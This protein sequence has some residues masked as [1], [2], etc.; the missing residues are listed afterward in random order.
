M[1]RRA[2]GG[3]RAPAW[4]AADA[5]VAIAIALREVAR[6]VEDVRSEAA[7]ARGCLSGYFVSGRG[8]KAPLTDNVLNGDL[9]RVP[10]FVGRHL[11]VPTCPKAGGLSGRQD[12]SAWVVARGCACRFSPSGSGSAGARSLPRRFRFRGHCQL[13]E[14]S[15]ERSEQVC[16]DRLVE[17]YVHDFA[18]GDLLALTSAERRAPRQ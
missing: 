17:Q 12:H 7:Q 5:C 18:D 2:R 10:V 4:A 3:G 8:R 6:A 11:T 16:R 15:A 1:A 14:V 9:P 13:W